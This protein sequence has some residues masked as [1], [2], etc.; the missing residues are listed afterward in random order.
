MGWASRSFLPAAIALSAL[1]IPA[2][3]EGL[4]PAY[5][6]CLNTGEPHGSHASNVRLW[7]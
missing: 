3:T 7:P 6:K 1:T 2:Y 5:K 4:S